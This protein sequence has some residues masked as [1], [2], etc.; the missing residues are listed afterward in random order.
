MV[1]IISS[2]TTPLAL[3]ALCVLVGA[4]IVRLILRQK[5]TAFAMV[6]V[7]Y[8]FWLAITL[9]LFANL[10]FIYSTKFSAEILITGV[11]RNDEGQYLQKVIVDIPGK[12]R[13]ITDDN[14]TFTMSIPQSRTAQSYRIDAYLRGYQRKTIDVH[15]KDESVNITLSRKILDVKE[16]LNIGPNV[17]VGHYLGLPQVDIRIQMFN[18]TDRTIQLK[19]MALQIMHEDTGREKSLFVGG[20]YFERGLPLMHPLPSITLKPATRYETVFLFSEQDFEIQQASQN[21]RVV[22]ERKGIRSP[23]DLKVGKPVISNRLASKLRKYVEEKWFWQPGKF[24]L[25][26]SCTVKDKKYEVV[27]SLELS[28]DKVSKMKRISNYFMSGFGI[29]YG[30]HLVGPIKDAQPAFYVH[31]K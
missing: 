18:P 28:G 10:A 16:L 21:V 24:K 8:G 12:A 5:P 20:M 11:V 3:A 17:L 23:Y 2:V 7:Q 29:F 27:R 1:P 26:F 15:S 22:F 30:Y 6:V 31:G 9:S 13:S 25:I 19:D 4:G 14:G